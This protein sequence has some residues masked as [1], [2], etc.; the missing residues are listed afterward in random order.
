MPALLM[1]TAT[2]EP[3]QVQLKPYSNRVGRGPT[4]DV[5]IDAK[6]ASRNHAVIDVEQAF[7]TI[8]DLGRPRARM[9]RVPDL[10][11]THVE[12]VRGTL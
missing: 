10:P 12:Q 9:G 3:R 2:G 5:I 6:V 4:N 7:V 8:T 11:P 1:M